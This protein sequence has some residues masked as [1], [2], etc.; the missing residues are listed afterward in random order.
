MSVP[1]T[2]GYRDSLTRGHAYTHD[3]A[4][5]RSRLLDH[6]LASLPSMMSRVPHLAKSALSSTARFRW[7]GRLEDERSVRRRSEEHV[8]RAEE[9]GVDERSVGGVDE[10]FDNDAAIEVMA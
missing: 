5:P 3:V 4:Q 6:T 10:H 1:Q 8:Y 7:L 2:D 9:R